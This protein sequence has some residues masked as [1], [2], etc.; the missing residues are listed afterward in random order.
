MLL[1]NP[2]TL[3][4]NDAYAV[5]APTSCAGVSVGKLQLKSLL[6]LYWNQAFVAN[7][8]GLTVSLNVAVLLVTPEAAGEFSEGGEGSE[9]EP[10]V[11]LIGELATGQPPF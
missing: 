8:L 4:P 10:V 2:V 6:V 7:P 3:K 11:K 9:G 1:L 5:P